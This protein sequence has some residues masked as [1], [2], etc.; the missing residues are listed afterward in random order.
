MGPGRNPTAISFI[1]LIALAASALAED[2][3]LARIR[4]VG[5]EGNGN[6]EAG[7]AWKELRS[8][9]PQE[10]P[11]LL[12]AMDGTSPAAANWLRAA[13]DAIAE[14][15]VADGQTL[16]ASK[17]EQFV[18]DTSHAPA[19]RRLAYEWLCR[20][21]AAASYRLLP[22]MLHDP[23]P[24]LRRDAGAAVMNQAK[25]LN[26]AGKKQEAAATYRKA[27]E[28]ASDKD[29]V[30]GILGELKAWAS[31]WTSRATSASSATGTSS[32]PF[33]APRDAISPP[34]MRLKKAWILGPLTKGARAPLCGG[35]RFRLVTLSAW[36]T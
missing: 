31:R 3:P 26:T 30:D 9:G 5:R 4:S 11:A 36:W 10:L 22:G 8:R 7:A 16:P 33:Q 19:P 35:S 27:F 20:V 23:S 24:E 13:V 21:D 34:C 17:L 2:Q 12:A 1:F 6:K 15:A 14:R 29:Q 28:G 18:K 25:S 32:V